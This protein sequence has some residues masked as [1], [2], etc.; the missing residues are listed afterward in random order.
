MI[1]DHYLHVQ[2]WRPNFSGED[3]KIKSLPVWVRFPDLPVQYFDEEWLRKAGD[4]MGRTLKV[5][6]TTRATARGR[7]ARVCVEIDM[8]KPLRA[9][10]KMKG[11]NYRLQYEGLHDLCFTC[12]K[13]G[14]R[15]AGCPLKPTADSSV[16]GEEGRKQ[17][18]G[19][20]SHEEDASPE[21][22]HDGFGPW[23]VAHRNRRRPANVQK[24]KSVNV[25]TAGSGRD[26][27]AEVTPKFATKDV[28]HSKPNQS[29]SKFST[30]K[31]A[32]RTERQP[33]EKEL[34]MQTPED[35]ATPSN[36]ALNNAAK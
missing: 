34:M 26:A 12:G 16:D 33:K 10:Y 7:F 24:G 1:G 27:Q 6:D 17:E 23:M 8:G 11:K 18:K 5:D 35:G 2:K 19:S 36:Q 15:E 3:A 30:A 4:E 9:N 13:Y 25:Q 21:A 29:G 32:T 20:R 22:K 31:K 28:E 14:H